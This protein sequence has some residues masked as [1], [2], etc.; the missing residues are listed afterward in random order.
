MEQ[1]G[2]TAYR[3]AAVSEGR[4][5]QRT[6]YRLSKGE[7]AALYPDEIAALV[8]IFGLGDVGELFEL[9]RGRNG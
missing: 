9:K 1:A 7:K 5:S 4:I 2:M 6:A 8:D 3:L